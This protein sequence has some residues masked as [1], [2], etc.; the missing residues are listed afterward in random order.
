MPPSSPCGDPHPAALG[1]AQDDLPDRLGDTWSGAAHWAVVADEDRAVY[2]AWANDRGTGLIRPVPVDAEAEVENRIS[3]VLKQLANELP[4]LSDGRID[5][6]G[7]LIA[8]VLNCVVFHEDRVLL[9]KRSEEVGA[10]RGKWSAVTG[11]VDRLLPLRDIVMGELMEELA[12]TVEDV[13]AIKYGVPYRLND[14]V[15][16]RAWLICPV[17]VELRSKPSIRLDWEHTA[18]RWIRPS[19]IE[20]F[21]TIPGQGESLKRALTG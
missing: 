18:Y 14:D 8:V 21:E 11:F 3:L 5:Y 19:D 7:S 9:L 1:D 17:L 12:L 10:Y 15:A 4:R 2:D 6:T 20:S 16:A 13:F